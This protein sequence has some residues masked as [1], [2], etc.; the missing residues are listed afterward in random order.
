MIVQVNLR[1]LLSGNKI[2][3]ILNKIFKKMY[4]FINKKNPN[5]LFNGDGS[6]FKKI[7][8]NSKTYGEYGCGKST[9]WIYNN[10]KND[11]ISVDTSKKWQSK[12]SYKMKDKNRYT[13][14]AI[15]CGEVKEWG[16]PIDH[17]KKENYIKYCKSIWMKDKKLDV[18]LIDGRFRV[19]CFLLSLKYADKDTFI[20]FDDYCNRP[21]YHVVEHLL[22]PIEFCGRQALF[23]VPSKKYINPT[24]LDVLINNFQYVTK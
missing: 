16:Y 5:F 22:K 8:S 6:L 10:T 21:R 18:V 11:I 9:L 12:I 1:R 23:Q 19:C 14:R 17:S 2:I 20:F 4:N 13:L 7:T 24:Y 15:D 3:K